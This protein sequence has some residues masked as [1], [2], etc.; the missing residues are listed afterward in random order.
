MKEIPLSQG[1]IALVD[2][3]DYPALSRMA[4]CA[5]WNRGA[6]RWEAM[7][8]ERVVVNGKATCKQISM[9]HMIM[10]R[11]VTGMCIDHRNGNQL[12]NQKYN[13]RFATR[14]QNVW[15]RKKSRLSTLP[16]KGIKLRVG[17]TYQARIS[18]PG[19]KRLSLG[20]NFR[21]PEQAAK[22]YNSA[23]IAFYGEFA[24]LNGLKEAA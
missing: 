20:S 17:G 4:W 19:G 16:Y 2:D 13:L 15:N 9:A 22:A 21:T 18:D 23:A 11:P 7:H 24:R 8:S 3:E 12:D 1:Q 14:Q 5:H 6:K 10:G